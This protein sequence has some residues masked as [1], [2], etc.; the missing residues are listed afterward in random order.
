[1]VDLTHLQQSEPQTTV[2][3]VKIEILNRSKKKRIAAATHG[4]HMFGGIGQVH[5]WPALC[6]VYFPQYENE[7]IYTNTYLHT[8]KHMCMYLHLY[9]STSEGKRSEFKAIGRIGP[10]TNEQQSS[11]CPTASGQWHVTDSQAGTTGHKY[12]RMHVQTMPTLKEKSKETNPETE[13]VAH[14]H[15]TVAPRSAGPENFRSSSCR[16]RQE[17]GEVT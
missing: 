14:P 13:M 6:I 12:L 9:Y 15:S 5:S 11:L 4:R 8:C 10:R 16:S 17:D 1:M 3:K 2:T 7:T